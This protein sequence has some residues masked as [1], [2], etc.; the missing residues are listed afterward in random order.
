MR[1]VVLAVYVL[2]LV[3][4]IVVFTA[5]DRLLPERLI[6]FISA[7]GDFSGEPVEVVI[8]GPRTE[9]VSVLVRIN[10]DG[11]ICRAI[12]RSPE[13]V[14]SQ[15]FRMQAGTM[16]RSLA[17][18]DTL[19]LDAGGHRGS[20]RVKAGSQWS[21]FGPNVRRIVVCSCLGGL[22]ALGACR[23]TC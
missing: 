9:M 3:A 4:G 5:P 6:S 20:Y 7:A 11:G 1:K 14:V 2:V 18:G 23:G 8:P 10:L 13:G 19:V 16:R 15:V 17:G 22:G 12:S 21:L